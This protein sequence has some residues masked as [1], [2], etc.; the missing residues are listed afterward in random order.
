MAG[1]KF[2]IPIAYKSDKQGLNQAQSDLDV[3]GNSLMKL[4]G[5]V[6]AAFSVGVIVDF[7][8]KSA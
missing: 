3:F 1:Q 4:G 2:V 6:A 7:A 8:A 5:I